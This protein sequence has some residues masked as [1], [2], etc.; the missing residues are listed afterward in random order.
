MAIS[1][2]ITIHDCA[3]ASQGDIKTVSFKHLELNSDHREAYTRGTQREYNAKPLK[4]SI[5]KRILEFKL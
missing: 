2:L 5:V 1:V 4:H 3:Q